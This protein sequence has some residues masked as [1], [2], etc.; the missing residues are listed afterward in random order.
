[1]RCYR[2]AEVPFVAERRPW[3][4]S[5]QLPITRGLEVAQEVAF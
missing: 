5:A 3:T 4:V 1:M 2:F